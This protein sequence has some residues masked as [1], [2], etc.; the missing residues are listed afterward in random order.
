MKVTGDISISI[1]FYF[2]FISYGQVFLLP[3]KNGFPKEYIFFDCP[4]FAKNV[5][6]HNE[7]L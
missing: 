3:S 6:L 1:Y 4:S 7:R 5:A 2:T